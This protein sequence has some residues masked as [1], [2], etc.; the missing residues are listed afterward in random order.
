VKTF[1]ATTAGM[2]FGPREE[3]LA[4]AI[5]SQAIE[6]RPSFGQTQAGGWRAA[7]RPEAPGRSFF[8]KSG[9]S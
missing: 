2:G 1:P 8:T 6:A 5:A 7:V 9:G 4:A 3:S